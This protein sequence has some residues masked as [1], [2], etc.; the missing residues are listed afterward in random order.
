VT[1]NVGTNVDSHSLRQPPGVVLG[2][3]PFNFPVMV[4]MWMFP[5][6]IACGNTFILKP[7]ERDPSASLLLADLFKQAG[8]PDGVFNVVNRDKGGRIHPFPRFN[9]GPCGVRSGAGP[10]KI[11]SLLWLVAYFI[12]TLLAWAIVRRVN[13]TLNL[14]LL[15]LN[16]LT[17]W[18]IVQ[19]RDRVALVA[20]GTVAAGTQ[21]DSAQPVLDKWV[22]PRAAVSFAGSVRPEVVLASCS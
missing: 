15:F 2:I 7:S 5:V 21:C 16:N 14:G 10:E 9:A 17:A 19:S 13:L 1:E 12:P 20:V 6:A 18:T 8:L 11:M 3:T 22:V 4:P